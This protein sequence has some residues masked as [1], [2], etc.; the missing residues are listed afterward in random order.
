MKKAHSRHK[1]TGVK[2]EKKKNG[3]HI[4]GGF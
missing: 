4:S 3:G 2:E 1:V